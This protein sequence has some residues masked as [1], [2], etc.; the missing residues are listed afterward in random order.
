MTPI[1]ITITLPG[2]TQAWPLPRATAVDTQ[3]TREAI[4]R[5]RDLGLVSIAHADQAERLL[6]VIEAGR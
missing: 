5:M 2:S 4:T 3:P 6:N 1:A